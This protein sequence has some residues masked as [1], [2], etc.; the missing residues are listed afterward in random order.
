VGSSAQGQQ[1]GDRVLPVGSAS[2]WL[3]FKV[4]LP[5]LPADNSYQGAGA[6]LDLT[7]NAVQVV[8]NP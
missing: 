8:N 5:L 7:F 1:T 2:E 3:C 4:V 6:T